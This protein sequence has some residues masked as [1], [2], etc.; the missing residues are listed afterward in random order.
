[1]TFYNYLSLTCM[2][3]QFV[4]ESMGSDSLPASPDSRPGSSSSGRYQ[5]VDPVQKLIQQLSDRLGKIESMVESSSGD[6]PP[7]ADGTNSSGASRPTTKDGDR[8]ISITN[9]AFAAAQAESSKD[10]PDMPVITRTIFKE[11]TGLTARVK[12]FE[13]AI[14]GQKAFQDAKD[15]AQDE[16]LAMEMDRINDDIKGRVSNDDL[17]KLER[18]FKN[19]MRALRT[20]L[21]ERQDKQGL[22]I[23]NEVGAGV[24]TL[25]DQVKV[26][27]DATKGIT[28]NLDSRLKRLEKDVREELDEMEQK[29]RE[30]VEE[31]VERAT[32]ELRQSTEAQ[33]HES[34]RQLEEAS[35]TI[36]QVASQQEALAQE[37]GGEAEKIENE[38]HHVTDTLSH[39]LEGGGLAEMIKEGA[40]K[41]IQDLGLKM[42]DELSRE[43]SRLKAGTDATRQAV[44]DLEAKLSQGTE[45]LRKYVVEGVEVRTSAVEKSLDE[46]AQATQ[47]QLGAQSQAL[48]KV[49]SGLEHTCVG[50]QESLAQAH[51]SIADAGAKLEEEGAKVDRLEAAIDVRVGGA[52]TRLDNLEEVRDANALKVESLDGRLG[53]VEV[54]AHKL[55]DGLKRAMEGVNDAGRSAARCSDEAR[56]HRRALDGALQTVNEELGGRLDEDRKALVGLEASTAAQRADSKELRDSFG[57]LVTKESFWDVMSARSKWHAERLGKHCN[58]TEAACTASSAPRLSPEATA[59][60]SGHAQRIAK[61]VAAQ[62]DAAVVKDVVSTAGGVTNESVAS[63][64]MA[65]DAKV[66]EMRAQIAESFVASVEK[67]AKRGRPRGLGEDGYGMNSYLTLLL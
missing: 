32:S 25:R 18:K 52:E 56:A 14:A 59:Y 21:E 58:D 45:E 51:A 63:L 17:D 61:V 33:L 34:K 39:L 26:I 30:I 20:E 1:M 3:V 13:D 8:K 42:S 37:T 27:N 19:E 36:A 5:G 6:A 47:Q 9:S 62:A 10:K 44:S 35:K 60:L 31:A 23:A 65:W 28:D 54:E 38:M 57:A 46:L 2:C 11:L 67:C 4:Q 22:K 66:D 49:A 43:A 55:G 7:D 41:D 40:S 64:A 48:D 53:S 24:R 15:K 12:R 29:T 50:L 16:M